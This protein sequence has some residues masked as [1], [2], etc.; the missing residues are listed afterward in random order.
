MEFEG[1]SRDLEGNWIYIYIWVWKE[2]GG[3]GIW[4]RRGG[5]GIWYREYDGDSSG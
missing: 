1:M 5:I 4:M 2:C 3:V